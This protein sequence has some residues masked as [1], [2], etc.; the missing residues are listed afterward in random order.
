MDL[1]NSVNIAIAVLVATIV[2]SIVRAVRQVNGQ[3][4]G[5]LRGVDP[6]KREALMRELAARVRGQANDT[7]CPRCDGVAFAM[8]GRDPWWKC[9]ACNW[10]F[11]GPEHLPMPEGTPESGH[12][13]GG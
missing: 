2:W 12:P 7:R 10:E 11:E 3:I 6:R 9:D 8:L 4:E 13:T 1:A 5:K